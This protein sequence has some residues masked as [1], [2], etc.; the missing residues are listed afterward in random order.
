MNENVTI[1]N[2]IIFLGTIQGLILGFLLFRTK[3]N[4]PAN[5]F[6]AILIF[7]LALASSCIYFSSVN[8]F[9]SPAFMY[10][11]NFIPYIVVMPIGPLIYFYTRIMLK[12][13]LRFSAKDRIHFFPV[14]IDLVPVLVAVF[15]VTGVATGLVKNNS[16]P[17]GRFIDEYDTYSDIPR[18]ISVTAYLL[19]SLR[20]LRR[21]GNDNITVQWLRHFLIVFLCFQLVW[22]IYLVPYV[23][24]A[25]SGFITDNFG[26]YPVYIPIA[27]LIYWLG[28]KGFLLSDTRMADPKPALPPDKIQSYLV[29]LRTSMTTDRVYLNPDLNLEILSL[30]TGIPPKLI[31]A[32]LNQHLEKG[33]SDFVNE[34]RIEEFKQRMANQELSRYSVAGLATDCG[35][36]SLATFQ[37]FFK[38]ITG[39]SPTQYRDTIQ[40]DAR[41]TTQNRI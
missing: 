30:H 21:S 29:S 38:K 26:W 19:F 41:R 22:L 1:L 8:Y 24:P 27:L 33:F 32:T 14:L 40:C 2:N 4:Q 17:Y 20:Y 37:R 25:Y 36:S 16:E 11:S 18:W 5:K 6:L 9:D 13:S 10:V 15:F 12:P 39:M 28:L 23:I 7:L 35:F 3:R 34:Y 31:S